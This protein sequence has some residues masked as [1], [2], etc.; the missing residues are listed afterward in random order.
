MRQR[1]PRAGVD[2][3]SLANNGNLLRAWCRWHRER[4][5]EALEG[6]HRDVLE[7]LM[8]QLKNPAFRTR[9]DHISRG[10]RLERD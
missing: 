1:L 4:L 5:E 2:R 3:E 7:R 10:T 9:A 8:M 6:V